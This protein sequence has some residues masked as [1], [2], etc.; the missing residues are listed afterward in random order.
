MDKQIEPAEID[1]FVQTPHIN[2]TRTMRISQDPSS[3]MVLH[4][5]PP[6]EKW[7]RMWEDYFIRQTGEGK[8][9]TVR[10]LFG[11]ARI[12]SAVLTEANDRAKNEV[13]DL[14]ESLAVQ[15]RNTPNG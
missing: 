5:E 4:A 11:Y 15:I 2:T 14:L 10:K 1:V 9:E 3:L 6:T 12:G 7:F 8:E 13:A